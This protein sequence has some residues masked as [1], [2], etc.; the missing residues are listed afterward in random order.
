VGVAGES[1]PPVNV[2]AACSTLVAGHHFRLSQDPSS[3]HLGTTVWDA[4]IVL[5]KWLEKVKGGRKLETSMVL[6]L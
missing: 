2:T 1:Q 5:A 6:V 3:L 4:S